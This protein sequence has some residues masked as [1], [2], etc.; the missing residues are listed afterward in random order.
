MPEEVATET[1]PAVVDE[2]VK[3]DKELIA[4]EEEQQAAEAEK[5][6]AEETEK[7]AKPEKAKKEKKAKVPFVFTKD[8]EE[9]KVYLYQSYRTP[10]IPS[11]FPKELMLETWLKLHGIP[12]ENVGVTSGRKEQTP[13]VELN[14]EKMA[15]GDLLPRLAQ[16]FEKNV[17]SHLTQDQLNIEHAMVKMVENHIYWFVMDWRT[18]SEDNTVKAYKLN[19]PAYF[20][21]S[22]PPA[23]LS[24][25]LKLSLCKKVQKQKRGQGFTNLE[26]QAKED[27]RVVSE[28]LG[29]KDFMFG[30]EISMLDLM[31]FSV[32]SLVLMVDPEYEC[33]MRDWVVET[34]PNLVDLVKRVK[35][36]VWGDHW[37]AA[38]GDN[39]DLNPHIPKPEVEP[40][41]VPEKE[42]NEEEKKDEE[43]E[44]LEKCEDEK[45]GEKEE[46][47]E[48][49]ESD[50]PKLEKRNS[51]MVTFKNMK[52][53]VFQKTKKSETDTET[54][55][56]T[57]EEKK[58]EENVEEKKDE[59]KDE[60]KADV[61]DGKKDEEKD[62]EKEP[63][64]ETEKKNSFID[65]LK[66]I[67]SRMAQKSK[68][69]TE[70]S[71]TDEKPKEVE[72]EKIED[73]TEEKEVPTQEEGEAEK[74]ASS[75]KNSIIDSLKNIKSRMVQKS[76]KVEAPETTETTAVV[77][78]DKSDE[79]VEEKVEEK[80]EEKAEAKAEEKAEE[81]VEEKTE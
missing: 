65:S 41:T 66:N 40:D 10:L 60:E 77:E 55:K 81:K 24:I 11:L 3:T 29:E 19:L 50:G 9:G 25:H 44:D 79:K 78:E 51:F 2:T 67:K 12:Y 30:S 53:R 20:Q 37:D 74:G 57:D 49:T 62:E 38:T 5:G 70:A 28:M 21:S 6:A 27:L 68:K 76:K 13:F 56:E 16:K 36:K 72:E 43:K 8:W 17:S 18:K 35:E 52:S 80:A 69:T 58:E 42:D 34:L 31:V 33:K 64:K 75:K 26:E 61:S 39:L 4:E 23:V 63:E 1:P 47:K 46:V 73:A 59:E 54:E 22:L 71:E 14:G 15:G 48:A 32:L 7:P 45:D